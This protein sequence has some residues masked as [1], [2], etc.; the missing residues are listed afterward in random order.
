MSATLLDVVGEPR[1]TTAIAVS[2]ETPLAP[3]AAAAP[4][5]NDAFEAIAY[6]IITAIRRL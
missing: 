1:K 5:I 4:Q 6:A 2:Q 3:V